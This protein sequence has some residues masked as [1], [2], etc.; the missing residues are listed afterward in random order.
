MSQKIFKLKQ[1]VKV[2]RHEAYKTTSDEKIVCKAFWE[3]L[4]DNDPKGAMEMIAIYIESLNKMKTAEKED[5]SRSTIYNSIKRK[6]PTI[7]TL[8]K[9]LHNCP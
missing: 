5:L 9:I 1:G 6:N 7:K 3:C 8:A 4:R 2:H